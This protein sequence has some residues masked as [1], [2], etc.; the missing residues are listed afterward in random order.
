MKKIIATVLAM[1]M[2]LALC[3]VAFADVK[4]TQYDKN[5]DKVGENYTITAVSGKYKVSKTDNTVDYYTVV[6]GGHT[7]YYTLADKSDY[8]AKFTADGKADMYLNYVDVDTAGLAGVTYKAKAVVFTN[9]GDDCAQLTGDKNKTYYKA[10][11]EQDDET[12][13][14]YYVKSAAATGTNL[15]VDGKLVAVTSAGDLNKHSWKA[16]TYDKD[17]NVLTYKCKDCGTVATVY[18]TKDAAAASGAAVYAKSADANNGTYTVVANKWL[19]W[20]DGSTTT[21]STDN[22]GNTSP[23]TFDAGIAMYVGMALTSV[24]GSAVV[25]GKKKEF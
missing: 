5:G 11:Y 4:Y 24:A 16:A 13:I 25:I 10:T 7:Y 17:D 19:A 23:K 21:P 2:A 15:L 14:E 22:K 9:I 1:V 8:N 3:T 12:K 20:T 18:N 6:D